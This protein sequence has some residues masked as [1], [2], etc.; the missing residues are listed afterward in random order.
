MLAIFGWLVLVIIGLQLSVV[1]FIAGFFNSIGPWTIGGAAN[2][3]G[4]RIA[5]AIVG[6]LIALYWYWLYTVCPFTI[7]V[8]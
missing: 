4:T 7:T 2:S 1:W 5:A 6:L 3:I 8:N